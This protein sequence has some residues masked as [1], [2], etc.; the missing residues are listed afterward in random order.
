MGTS[1]VSIAPSSVQLSPV[2]TTN[3][4]DEEDRISTLPDHI[5]LDILERLRDYRAAIQ[6]GTLARR[7][8]RL[9]LLL[10][11]L[12]VDIADFLPHDTE[13][14]E[15]WTVD[16]VMTAY[17]TT[18]TRLLQHS[19]SSSGQAIKDIQLSFYLT[20]P[21]LQSIDHAVGD[22]MERGN[23]DYL[24]IT[25]WVDT[26]HPSYEQCV[27]FGQR[28]MAFLHACPTMFRWFT[29]LT[30]QNITFGD[31]D[32]SSLLNTCNKLE[33][34]SLTG[35]DSPFDPVTGEDMALTINAPHSALL[36]LEIRTYAIHVEPLLVK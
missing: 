12:L 1:A 6:V 11:R 8:V 13:R 24:D 25:I 35:C 4:S 29:R 23:T 33:L 16:Q 28:F 20:D 14:R 9:P 22:L 19:S 36:A 10:S 26:A 30:L 5:L 34:L 18:L 7:W 31:S 21:Y 27:L 3:I 2:N 32:I 15:H 17:T